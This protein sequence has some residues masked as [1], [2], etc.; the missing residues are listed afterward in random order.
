MEQNA[1]ENN[2]LPQKDAV[3]ESKT[4]SVQYVM[5]EKSKHTKSRNGRRRNIF[6]ALAVIVLVTSVICGILFGFV[7]T[8]YLSKS[9]ILITQR[10]FEWWRAC[11]FWFVGISCSTCLFGISMIFGELKR[12]HSHKH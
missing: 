8:T 10:S 3:T 11:L 5:T 6:L 9:L 2:N 4:D 12:R 7:E 1:F